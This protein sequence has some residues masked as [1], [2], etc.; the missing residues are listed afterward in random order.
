MLIV[1]RIQYLLGSLMLAIRARI[2]LSKSA[3]RRFHD[4]GPATPYF[5]ESIPVFHVQDDSV[6]LELGIP[7]EII[8]KIPEALPV[9]REHAV[10]VYRAEI[11]TT[12]AFEKLPAQEQLA[13]F[14]Y[15]NKFV[16]CVVSKHMEKGI[17]SPSACDRSVCEV[18]AMAHTTVDDYVAYRKKLYA[19]YRQSE[20]SRLKGHKHINEMKMQLD[21]LID[22]VNE[23]G[24]YDRLGAHN[25]DV[26]MNVV[27]MNGI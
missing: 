6:A 8:S 13:V 24:F 26:E 21:E 18:Y 14:H 1:D 15:L 17:L 23:P 10:G 7:V 4:S 25:N 19:A 2:S 9:V 16:N 27:S 22:H 11:Y 20:V 12:S 3:A 5:F